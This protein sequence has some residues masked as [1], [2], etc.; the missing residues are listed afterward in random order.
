[1]Q[2]MQKFQ[3]YLLY[4]YAQI[5]FFLLYQLISFVYNGRMNECQVYNAI[6]NIHYFKYYDLIMMMT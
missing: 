4:N 6:Y 2:I 3:D 1:M 5:V